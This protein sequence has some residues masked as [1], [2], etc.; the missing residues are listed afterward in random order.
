MWDQEYEYSDIDASVQDDDNQQATT[1]VTQSSLW[2]TLLLVGFL[3]VAVALM[4][5]V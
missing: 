5:H 3:L 2:S 4:S 1:D